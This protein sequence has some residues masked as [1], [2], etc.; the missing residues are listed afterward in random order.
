MKCKMKIECSMFQKK[1]DKKILLNSRIVFY[2]F[3]CLYKMFYNTI[4]PPRVSTDFK[5]NFVTITQITP[6]TTLRLV[7]T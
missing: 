3:L 1:N 4:T 7:K 5:V 2:I 6:V